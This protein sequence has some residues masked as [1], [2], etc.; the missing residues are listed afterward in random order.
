M[1]GSDQRT[2]TVSFIGAQS[3]NGGCGVRYEVKLTE[4]PTAVM[5]TRISHPND[6]TAVCTLMGFVRSASAVVKAPLGARVLVD[7][8]GYPMGVSGS[9]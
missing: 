7:D 3:E 1:V 6:S 2:L 5:A 8:L 9:P 4:S